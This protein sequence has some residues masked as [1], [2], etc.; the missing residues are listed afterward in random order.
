[1]NSMADNHYQLARM[2]KK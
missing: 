2:E 1:M